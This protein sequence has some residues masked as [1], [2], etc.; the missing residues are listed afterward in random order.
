MANVNAAGPDDE[1]P[2][3][4]PPSIVVVKGKSTRK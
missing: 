3:D 2:G 4:E 1:H